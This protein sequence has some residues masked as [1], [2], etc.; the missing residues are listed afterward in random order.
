VYSAK[1]I[2]REEMI[3]PRVRRITGALVLTVSVLTAASI[4]PPTAPQ[5]VPLT[6][7]E[8]KNLDFAGLVARSDLRGTFGT[9]AQVPG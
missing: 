5:T 6:V 9:R 8:K 1:A 2:Y 7:Q 4:N 3:L